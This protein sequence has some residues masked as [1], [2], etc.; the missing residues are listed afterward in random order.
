VFKNNNKLILALAMVST[1]ASASVEKQIT[2]EKIMSDPLWMGSQPT[3]ANWLPDSRHVV[4]NQKVEGSAV[5]VQSR[6]DTT[7]PESVKNVAVEEFHKTQLRQVTYTNT[8]DKASYVFEGDIFVWDVATSKVSQ[9]TA[10][11]DNESSPLFLNNGDLSYWQGNKLFV[12]NFESRLAKESATLI[13]SE[14]PKAPADPDDIIAKEQHKLIDY[15]S[16]KLADKKERFEHKKSIKQDNAF[17]NNASFYFGKGNRVSAKVVSPNG[18][19]L[20]VVTQKVVPSR[21]KT[22]L[23][24]NYIA[25]DGRIE[26]VNVRQRVADAKPNQQS[27][28]IIDL[29]SH[30]KKELT[31][32]SLPDF[33][34]DVLAQVKVEN[35]KANG[36]T[37]K[38]EPKPRTINLINDW[39]WD[40]GAI[41]W[42]KNGKQVAVM[43]EAW[44]NKDRWLTTVNFEKTKFV[45][46][47]QL[48][49]DAWINYTFN[50]YGWFNQ[51]ET[52]YFLSEQSGYSHLYI[53]RLKDDKEQQITKGE[54]EVST[55]YLTS[56]DQSFI[57]RANVNHPGE[58]H[59]YKV[60]TKQRSIL[61][62]KALTTRVGENRFKISPNEQKLLITHSTLL[63]HSDLY[64][65]DING[66]DFTRLTNTVSDE[67]KSMP[68][69]QPEIVKVPSSHTDK[70]I[71]AKVYYPKDYRKGEARKA[72]I[73]NHGAG[74]LQ[75][76]HKGW[77]GYFRE[78]M[79]HNMLTQQGYVV[80]DMDYRA[81]KGYGR[82]WRTA[83]YRQMGT[84]E[85]QDLVD[86]VDWLVKNANVDR[87]RIGTY[88]GSYGGFMTFM[89][90][91]TEP[92]LFQAG[93]AL[94]P[95]SDWAHYN[96]GYTS[97]I[98]NR[99]SD[100][101]IAYRRSS[102]IYFAE[103]LTKPL[104]INAPMVDNN[105][106]FVDVVR[107]VQRFIELE[108]EDFETAIYPVEP[109]GF[110]Q[111]SSWLDEYRRIYKLFEE[112]L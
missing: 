79:F 86:G 37:Y 66:N 15:V 4:F 3:S 12:Y 67:F 30:S 62:P 84:P 56:N 34:K 96:D 46:Q 48:H 33:D 70:P 112:N 72:V 1:V 32:D 51:E 35:A 22:D 94:R 100:D 55:P 88:G 91:F 20:V 80:M 82:D 109:H 42:H 105:V 107:L 78:F 18:D 5:S 45:T 103:G 2:L 74:Y 89:A 102:P 44:D 38:S 98:L 57:F 61:E 69:K 41:Q 75:N 110:V 6:L 16:K 87:K 108:K 77:S 47:H 106:F 21:D 104:L 19:K 111:P 71:Y 39:Y 83:I 59:V 99:P 14:E 40:Q 63:R 26:M 64:V 8:R 49:D 24:P 85:T 28:Y 43:L 68:F 95:V 81:S 27:F 7:N 53:K 23:M 13:M 52:L 9:V 90:L 58:Y 29:V 17:V 31:I 65:M 54:F 101:M 92:D 73:F 60:S 36:E 10:T 25:Q 11:S 76:S 97:N 50:E 93:A